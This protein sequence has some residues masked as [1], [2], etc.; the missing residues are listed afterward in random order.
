MWSVLRQPQPDALGRVLLLPSHLAASYGSGHQIFE[1][2]LQYLVQAVEYQGLLSQK[3][4]AC[5]LMAL[6]WTRIP[7]WHK[8]VLVCERQALTQ[9]LVLHVAPQMDL[10]HME[11]T[12]LVLTWML[13]LHS[14]QDSGNHHWH[15]V[16]PACMGQE[17]VFHLDSC[18]ALWRDLQLTASKF[19]I[20]GQSRPP[21]F[22]VLVTLVDLFHYWEA[23]FAQQYE[24]GNDCWRKPDTVW[25]EFWMRFGFV[26]WTAEF[27]ST[28]GLKI[29]ILN[30]MSHQVQ[31]LKSGSD[32]VFTLDITI[33]GIIKVR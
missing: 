23:L 25:I 15:M 30:L 29:C 31:I 10:L 7:H 5:H 26:C 21:V 2:H 17:V 33:K 12:E 28:R 22:L 20:W 4:P 19:E 11:L 24:S 32:Q 13:F 14:H 16:Q 8:A 6:S 18:S 9:L 27:E 3:E 1:T